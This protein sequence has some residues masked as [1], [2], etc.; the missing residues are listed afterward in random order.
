[1]PADILD[2]EGLTGF[3]RSPDEIARL[4]AALDRATDFD[5]ATGSDG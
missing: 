3:V 1:M 2:Y 4:V 5:V